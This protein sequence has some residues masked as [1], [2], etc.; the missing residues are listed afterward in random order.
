MAVRLCSEHLPNT[1]ALGN[2]AYMRV[3]GVLLRSIEPL[4]TVQFFTALQNIKRILW[5]SI[6]SLGRYIESSSLGSGIV[7]VGFMAGMPII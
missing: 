1:L 5:S 2:T 7:W 3:A 4:N 6:A